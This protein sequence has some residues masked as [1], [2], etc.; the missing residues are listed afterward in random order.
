MFKDRLKELLEAKFNGNQAQLSNQTQIPKT[1]INGWLTTEREPN[2]RQLITLAN[3]FECSID[4]LVGRENEIGLIEI[5]T[6]IAEK[7]NNLL[8]LFRKLPF[9]LQQRAY[10]YIE[11]LV[12]NL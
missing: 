12:V 10:G 1:T 11:A 5:Q 3:F 7:E 2:S 8:K 6:N 4:Y 9:N